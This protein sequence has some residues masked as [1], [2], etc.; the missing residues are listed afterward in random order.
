MA[1]LQKGYLGS[2]PLWRDILW[3]QGS[4]GIIVDSS[5]ATTVTANTAA[6]TK[7]AWTQV[8][9]ST[10]ANASYIY[11][12]VNG[13]NATS[14]NTATLLDIATGAS[15]SETAIVSNIAIGAANGVSINSGV[16]FSFPY[17]LA[18]GTRLSARIQSVVT[19][20]KTASV[21]INTI[22]A[23]DYD[24]SPTSVDVVGGNT[25]TSEG[26]RFSGASGTW[27][28]ATASTSRAYRAVALVLSGHDSVMANITGNYGVGVGA[29]GSEVEFGACRHAMNSSEQSAS[30]FP[31]IHLFGRNI[32]SG[33][34][35]A[36]RH[37]ITANPERYGFN[38]IGIP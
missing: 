30:A 38:L 2:T 14:V 21:A 34:R 33:S 1:L 10:T 27:V 20:G 22:N 5:A 8:I 23:G 16:V 9:A 32:P 31:F 35:L 18:S 11:V 26:I 28:Q 12:G 19:G 37:P 3:Y 6:H 17:R 13:V 24:N 4:G 15:G 25:A 36:V 7:G 29:S